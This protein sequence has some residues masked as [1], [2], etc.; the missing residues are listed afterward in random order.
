MRV[1]AGLEAVRGYLEDNK[2]RHVQR[3]QR[4]IRQPS[5]STEDLGVVECADLMAELHREAGLQEVEVVRTPGLPGVWAYHDAGAPKTIAVYGNF[6]TRPVLPHEVWERPPYGGELTSM[7]GFSSVLVG[8]G[9]YSYKG[10]YV[11]WLNALEALLAVDGTLPVN[12]MILLEGDEILGSPNYREMFAR[13]RDRLALA[14]ASLSPGASQDASGKVTMSLGYKGMVYVDLV[15]SGVSWGRGPQGGPLHGM[16]KS[17]VDSPVW[18]LVH[19]LASLTEPDGN[20]V[21]VQGFYDDLKPPTE[22]ERRAIGEYK[23][24]LG[25]DG[26]R[27][28]LPGVGAVPAPAGDLSDEETITNYFYG[29]SLNINGIEGGFTGPGTLPFSLPHQASA[30]FDIRV[31]RGYGADRTVKLIRDHLDAREYGDVEMRVMGAFD[32]STAP[33]ESELVRC[34]ERAFQEMD[35]PLVMSPC[36][37]G[38]GPWSMCNTELGMPVIRSVGVGGGGGAAGP[39]E[40]MVIEGADTVGG[41]VECELSHVHMLKSYARGM[42]R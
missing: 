26:W 23:A 8:R 15:S 21:A 41:L 37:G 30:R 9:A 33:R 3:I 10:P 19:A 40:Y 39:N 7:G 29:P 25:A 11:A 14:D 18:R 20:R 34:L 35:V 16:A 24:S 42:D 1:G 22:E 4:A 36:S 27:R 28:V 31:P 12:V 32:P 6:D 17:V 13:Y 38:G 5:V 2:S